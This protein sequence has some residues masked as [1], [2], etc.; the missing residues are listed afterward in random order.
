MTVA[1]SP[2]HPDL[3][4]RSIADLAAERGV[5]PLDAIVEISIED[6]LATRF[7]STLA[8]NDPDMIEQLLQ[9]DG[10]LIGLSD[11]GAHVGQL[12]DA[13]LPTDL[14]GNWVREREVLSLERAVHKLSGEPAGVF[15]FADR[16]TIA[17]GKAADVTVFDPD[18]VAPGKLRPRPRLPCRRRAAGRRRSRR[19]DARGRERHADP[20]GRCA[21]GRGR[22]PPPRSSAAEH[23]VTETTADASSNLTSAPRRTPPR[24][25]AVAL[26]IAVLAIAAVVIIDAGRGTTFF[27]DEWIWIMQR[28]SPGATS[29]L[30]PFNNHLMALPIATYQVLFRVF[31][32]DSQAPY[33][34]VLLGGHLATCGLLY[35]YLRTPH[36]LGARTRRR[37]RARVLRLLVGRHH[38]ADL[39]RMGVRHHGGDRRPAPRRPRHAP[40]RRR[41]DGT[42][43]RRDRVER[44]RGAIR[45]RPDGGAG[46]AAGVAPDLRVGRRARRVR[47]VVPRLRQAARAITAAWAT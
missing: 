36:R 40:R 10:M 23:R 38:L 42:A 37:G 27:Y 39:A 28:R 3:E 47:R 41:S 34:L 11:A 19:D 20:R 22:R 6:D 44:D 30:E 45:H 31:G 16:G 29:L 26:P 7:R 12:C 32:L 33:R 15:G 43:A 14:L 8:N 5:E 17:E 18:T 24:W 4:D 1:E 21:I 2:G 35:V 46:G 13:C 9:Q 25:L